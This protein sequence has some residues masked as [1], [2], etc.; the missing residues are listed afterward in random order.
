MKNL[1]IKQLRERSSVKNKERTWLSRLSDERLYE[2][3]L[4]LR[5]GE[6]SRSIAR[7]AQQMW[8]VNPAS[9]IHS[10]SQGVTKFRRRISQLIN[11]PHVGNDP[12]GSN[13]YLEL[14]E[15]TT[16]ERMERMSQDI[17]ARI[18]RMMKEEQET[19][20]KFPHLNRDI[21]ALA[22]LR[23]SIIKQRDWQLIHGD[24]VQAQNELNME[25]NIKRKFDG[26]LE[27]LGDDSQKRLICMM[28]NFLEMAEKIAIPGEINAEGKLI[29][30]DNNN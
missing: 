19:G 12:I 15:E 30:D 13:P 5:A 16:L 27:Y 22:S 18:N 29:L 24:S 8:R 1:I 28:H 7:H 9:S 17:E 10:L 23:K 26:L 25:K 2:V 11:P 14:N 6:S 4:K 21:Q 3:F 20:I